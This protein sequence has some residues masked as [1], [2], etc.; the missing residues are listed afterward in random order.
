[1]QYFMIRKAAGLSLAVALFTGGTQTALA[2]GTPSGIPISN[3]ATVDYQVGTNPRSATGAAPDILVDNRVDLMVANTDSGN[4]VT[5]NPGQ[6]DRILTYTVTNTGNTTQGYLLTV[7]VP[8]PTANIPMGNIRIYVDAN[9]DGVP[10]PGELYTPG[11]NAGDLDPNG[12]IGTDDVM[13]VLVVAD[14]PAG[15]VDATQDD[16]RLVARTTNAGTSTPTPVSGTPTAGVDVVWADL[17]GSTS[18]ADYDG[19]YS[20]A[21]TFTVQSAAVTAA[22]TIVSTTDEFGSGFAIPG[23]DVVYQIR[24]TNS[25]SAT[26][27][28]DTVSVTDAIPANSQL[29]VAT[30]GNCTAPTFADGT[31]SSGLAGAAFEYSFT[32]G[33]S[34]CADASFTGTA[35]TAD[36]NGYDAAVTC[37]RQQPTGSMSGSGGYFDVQI[38]VGIQ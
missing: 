15:A 11:T 14:T 37:V 7:D 35:P 20:A 21:A 3:T 6:T 19:Q 18:E 29:C 9:N 31:T 26:V 25:G 13:Q 23:A 2:V 30:T 22:K 33:A 12:V 17:S 10:D 24:V 32:A 27:D 28:A 38:T 34:A 5:V 16:F 4:N 1:M 8:V 36:A